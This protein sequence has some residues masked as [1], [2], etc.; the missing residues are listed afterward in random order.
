[1]VLRDLQS[2]LERQDDFQHIFMPVNG[3]S[4]HTVNPGA[5]GQFCENSTLISRIRHSPRFSVVVILP[6]DNRHPAADRFRPP[7]QGGP[8]GRM[9][10][11]GPSQDCLRGPCRPAQS[12]SALAARPIGPPAPAFPAVGRSL[13]AGGAAWPRLAWAAPAPPPAFSAMPALLPHL[14]KGEREHRQMLYF[15][16]KNLIST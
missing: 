12:L 11:P 7:P 5:I 1:M 10:F 13:S 16:V 4:C 15:F 3:G 6:V 8:A 9:R 2:A 14:E